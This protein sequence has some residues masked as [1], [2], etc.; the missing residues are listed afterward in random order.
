MFVVVGRFRFQEMEPQQKQTL[1]ERMA[2]DMPK[3]ARECHG[4][5]ALDLV[6]V[7]EES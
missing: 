1:M 4:F 5:Q 6:Q 2:Q 3:T 7:S